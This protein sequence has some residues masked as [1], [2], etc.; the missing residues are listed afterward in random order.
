MAITA[1]Y[2]T[3][4]YIVA[5]TLKDKIKAD[6][7][8]KLHDMVR[9]EMEEVITRAANELVLRVAEMGK[10]DAFGTID[11]RVIIDGAEKMHEELKNGNQKLQERV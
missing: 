5:Q 11:L 8:K 4:S 1:K 2:E 3:V 10:M 9:E 6:L 7:Y